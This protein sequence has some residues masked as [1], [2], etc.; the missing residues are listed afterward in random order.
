MAE[1]PIEVRE[2]LMATFVAIVL[3]TATTVYAADATL[4]GTAPLMLDRPVDV[5]MVEGIHRFCSRELLKS[6]ERRSALWQRDYSS[7]DA[8]NESIMENRDRFRKM[9]GATDSRVSAASKRL[10]FE[11]LATLDRSSIVARSQSVT[12]HE[13]KWQVLEGVTAEGLLL[14]PDR[15]RA[16]VVALPDADW[17]PEM[18]CGISDSFPEQLQFVRWLAKAGCLVAIPTMI[19]RSDEF[20]GHPDVGFTNLPHREFL[21]RQAFEMG[22]HI[23]GFEVQKVLAAVDLFEQH[24]P[25][26]LIGVAGVGEG[27]LIALCAA[28]LDSRIDSTLVSG[29]FQ[30]R[31]E[32]WREP[33]YRN[34]W[35]LLTEFGDAELAGMVTPRRLVIEACR[36]EEVAGPPEVTKGHRDSA[37]PGRITTCPLSSVVAEHRRGAVHYKRLGHEGEFILAVSDKEGRGLAGSAKALSTFSAALAVELDVDAE[38]EKWE[39]GRTPSHKDRQQRQLDEMQAFVQKLLRQS[40]KVRAAKWKADLSS[41]ETWFP[42]RN[43][44]RNMVHDELIGRL[45]VRRTPPNPRTRL[46][47]DTE[48]YL[49]YEVVLD[50]AP[51]I[52]AAGILLLP[53]NMKP[54]EKRPVVI[55]QHGLE[56]T[57]MDTISRKPPA[58]RAYK[59]F[60]AELCRRGFIVY[61]PQNPYRGRDRFRSIQRKANPLGLSLFSF[62]I[63]QHRTTLNWLATL[64]NIDADRMAF[65]GLSYGGKTAMRVPPFVDRYCLSICSGDFTDWVKTIATNEEPYAYIFTGEYEIPEWNLGHVASYAELAM[66]MSPRPF[67]VEAGHRDGGQPTELV[68]AEFGKVRRHYDTL[69]I[70]DRAELEFFDGPH[71]INGKGT[72]RFL[73]YHLNWPE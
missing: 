63:E 30:E 62:I 58:F 31:E 28:A 67:M 34:V 41:V 61:S 40:H 13:I 26:L 33:I 72:F 25:D 70:S 6:R 20:S 64:P 18:L 47:L 35:R 51:D 22:R 44:F 29:Y 24:S 32:M 73:H 37:A 12:V 42:A 38:P 57:A 4:S 71:T 39:A 3:M 43:R 15:I 49:G 10:S 11:L 36:V 50:V 48:D 52:I 16:A 23:I 21:Y 2:R 69:R 46:I 27:G 59:A 56:A 60:A 19:S 53:K 5:V 68:A 9:I 66:L 17:T 7:A 45:N 55:C 54:D 14:K 8:Y 65:Y 1:R